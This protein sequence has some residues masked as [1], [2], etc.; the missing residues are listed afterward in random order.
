MA[1]LHEALPD[2]AIAPLLYFVVIY[3]AHR[4]MYSMN[5][6]YR[7]AIH[8]QE[9]ICAF[10]TTSLILSRFDWSARF[11][12]LMIPFGTFFQ[13]CFCG[14]T[15]KGSGNPISY[16]YQDMIKTDGRTLDNL[17]TFIPVVFVQVLGS[18]LGHVF[19]GWYWSNSIFDI[20]GTF[21][22]DKYMKPATSLSVNP[23]QGAVM[24]TACFVILIMAS[25]LA[26]RKLNLGNTRAI[27]P[28]NATI[29]TVVVWWAVFDTGA[30]INPALAIGMNMFTW[31]TE[32]F[33]HFFVYWLVPAIAV[34]FLAVY[35]TAPRK[36]K[37][38]SRSK[39]VNKIKRQG[40][41][42]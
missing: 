15:Y 2:E 24:E 26:T 20:H 11:G 12:T 6:S 9:F 1:L 25:K 10:S 4:V 21:H 34:H 19:F 29:V 13:T 32:P 30:M 22:A 16:Y 33:T 35:E 8:L 7:T 27:M 5:T 39:M 14:I 28:F 36:N 17:A 40:L 42:F 38:K 3:V 23:V 18:C 31:H 37:A 41:G